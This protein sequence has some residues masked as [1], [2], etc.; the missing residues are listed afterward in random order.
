MKYTNE[1]K[2]ILP[3]DQFLKKVVNAE[4]GTSVAHE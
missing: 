3:L 1:I 4:K 2:A